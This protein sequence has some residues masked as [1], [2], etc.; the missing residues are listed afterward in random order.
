MLKT[1]SLACFG[2]LLS[3]VLGCAADVAPTDTGDLGPAL[4]EPTA[5]GQSF[6]VQLPRDVTMESV[7]PAIVAAGHDELAAACAVTPGASIRILNPLASGTFEDVSCTTIL[8]GGK[9]VEQASQAITS[10]G[11]RI[12][13]VQQQGVITTV[14]CFAGG[15]AAFLV[16]RYGI[17]PHGRTEQ[18][19]TNCNDAGGW[20]G[21]GIGLLCGFTALF[22]F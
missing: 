8:D 16:P 10:G 21:L 15:A 2:L 20:G 22:P 6:A 3:G 11:E 12:G 7:I 14:A 18:D 17:C 13:Q 19:R 1:F 5:E 9:S 4:A